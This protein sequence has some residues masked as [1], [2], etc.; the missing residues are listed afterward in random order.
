MISWNATGELDL[1]PPVKKEKGSPIEDNDGNLTF[2]WQGI[3]SGTTKH[4]DIMKSTDVTTAILLSPCPEDG[5]LVELRLLMGTLDFQKKKEI[6]YFVHIYEQVPNDLP[7]NLASGVDSHLALLTQRMSDKYDPDGEPRPL[8]NVGRRINF[9][10]A[11]GQH[12]V[13]VC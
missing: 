7:R 13:R 3:G 10:S 8:F 5:V 11:S 2:G 4:M 12:Y 1:K 6:G 9:R